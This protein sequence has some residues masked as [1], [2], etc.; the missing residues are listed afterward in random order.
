MEPMFFFFLITIVITYLLSEMACEPDSK[1]CKAAKKNGKPLLGERRSHS[2]KSAWKQ[3]LVFLVVGQL[4]RAC[5]S[6]FFFCK[7]MHSFHTRNGCLSF[8]DMQKMIFLDI[9]R[10][11]KSFV[12]QSD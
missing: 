1:R 8:E 7:H 10:L 3:F 2:L 12:R 5:R 6:F 9:F 11:Y 4:K